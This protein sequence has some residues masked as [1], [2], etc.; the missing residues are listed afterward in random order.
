MGWPTLAQGNAL[1][2]RRW[3]E[4]ALWGRPGEGIVA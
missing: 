3:E 1:G 2:E 4:R